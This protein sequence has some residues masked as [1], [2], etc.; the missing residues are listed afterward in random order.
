MSCDNNNY[1]LGRCKHDLH[2]PRDVCGW[3]I[4]YIPLYV[5][6]IF[7]S[8]IYVMQ[9]FIFCFYVF[10]QMFFF[11]QFW[12]CDVARGGLPCARGKL[13]NPIQLFSLCVGV[14]RVDTERRGVRRSWSWTRVA[15]SARLKGRGLRDLF[16]C[17]AVF[18]DDVT[19]YLFFIFYFFLFIYFSL[20]VC[21][22]FYFLQ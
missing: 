13:C 5:M 3:R 17:R 12:I 8:C 2:V 20:C 7:I 11:L 19:F 1:V 4:L 15:H 14:F 9:M 18:A 6:Q 22:C 21:R 16:I 10:L